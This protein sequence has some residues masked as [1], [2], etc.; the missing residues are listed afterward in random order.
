M[1]KFL[2]LLD[3]NLMKLRLFKFFRILF[4][5]EI[6]LIS[7]SGV[8]PSFE[9][10]KSLRFIGKVNSLVDCGSNKG[11]FAIMVFML[12]KNSYYLGFDPIVEPKLVIKFLKKRN[13][14]TYFKKYA[15]S[16][17]LGIKDFYLTKRLDSSSLKKPKKIL[18]K[19]FHEVYE[20]GKVKVNSTTLDTFLISIKN[21][22]EPRMLKID[23]Q[24]NEFELLKG[25]LESLYLFKY[26]IV[27]CNYQK[28]YEG[29]NYY[30]K[31]ID[32]FMLE[33]NFKLIKEYNFIEK[34]KKIIN[35]DRLY[36][37]KG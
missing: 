36:I 25:A 19:Y 15:L 23:V 31:D 29:D 24:G 3:L 18:K 27:E 11:Q 2:N 4:F 22:P 8:I 6:T 13:V 10:E 28:I 35:V 14:K 7:L 30:V 17:E 37:Y 32:G 20:I 9:H 26:I 16:N 21:L 1:I 33:N 12:K 34:N 5:P